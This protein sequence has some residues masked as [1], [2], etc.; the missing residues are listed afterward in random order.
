MTLTILGAGNVLLAPQ[1]MAA[2]SNWLGERLEITLYDADGERLDLMDRL[3]RSFFQRNERE[4]GLRATDVLEE[5]LED[6]SR[7][8]ILWD[9]HCLEIL[10][11]PPKPRPL[12][13]RFIPTTYAEFPEPEP[14]NPDAEPSAD[15]VRLLEGYPSVDFAAFASVAAPVGVQ[16]LPSLEPF[17]GPAEF[18]PHQILR[19]IE[20]DDLPNHFLARHSESPVLDWIRLSGAG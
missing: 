3:A 2:L 13:S 17:P 1:V 15:A 16:V 20:G 7:A 6:S 8:L 11:S 19:W 9:E 12:G 14:E 18:A 10:S 5:S 4:F